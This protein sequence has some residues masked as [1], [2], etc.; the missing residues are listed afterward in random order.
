MLCR[1][2]IARSLRWA[3]IASA[4]LLLLLLRGDVF[5][6]NPAR[7]A[8]SRYAFDLIGWHLSN[9]MSKWAHLARRGIPGRSI[10]DAERLALVDEYFRLGRA[11]ND[12]KN[13]INVVASEQSPMAPEAR[14]LQAELARAH[15]L[16]HDVRNDVEEALE[17]ELSSVVRAEG[18]G[19]LGE[20]VIP[21]VDIRLVE[22]PKALITSPRDRIERRDGILLDPHISVESREEIE[23][24][25]LKDENIS[26]LV[27]DIGG[28]ATYPASVYNGADL[29]ATL[30]IMAHEW[31]HHYLFL[32]PLGQHM[33]DSPDM[34]VLNETV[35]DLGGREL[36]ES[37]FRR[38]RSRMPGVIPVAFDAT[39]GIGDAG[40]T[41][42][43]D[44]D[45]RR[46][47]QETR[48][49]A[50]AL[51]ARDEIE[52][53][54]AYMETRRKLFVAN[55]HPIRKLNQA[56][57]AFNGAYAESPASVNPIGGQ[58]RRLRELSP[59]LG[60]F[61][62]LVSGVSDYPE[63]L[64]ILSES[65]SVAEVRSGPRDDGRDYQKSV[66]LE[67]DGQ[68]EGDR[69]VYL[70]LSHRKQLRNDTFE[71]VSMGKPL[72]NEASRCVNINCDLIHIRIPKV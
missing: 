6:L 65:E 5:T 9:S 49:T 17:S 50:D 46:E 41:E 31:L 14:R 25:L 11:E 20:I 30:S 21:P 32:R 45:F 29:N 34:L 36:G 37:A 27:L 23:A 33:F 7:E 38:I 68:G 16:R 51:L 63:F 39:A 13:R 58:V 43:A 8:S 10:S 22:T 44:F 19:L 26:A 52:I 60:A 28:V 35:A 69:L 71:I 62:S 70:R 72:S 42:T 57:F 61:M 67:G 55:G 64:E 56:Y 59:D 18:M 47:M 3:V 40:T 54:E 1:R 53:A 15:R 12:L 24:G 2:I 48:M 66:S 4:V